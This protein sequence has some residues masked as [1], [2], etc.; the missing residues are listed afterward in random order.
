MLILKMVFAVLLAVSFASGQSPLPDLRIE[1]VGG[2]SVMYVTN[3]ASQPLTAFLIELAGYP[4]SSYS[5]AQDDLTDVIAPGVEK[6]IQ[7]SNMIIGAAP[8]YVKIRAAIFADGFTAGVAEKIA[9]TINRRRAVLETTRE[10]IRRIEKAV[11][12]GTEK[13]ALVVDLKEWSV[14]VRSVAGRSVIESAISRLNTHSAEET[15]ASLHASES[16]LAASKP[17]L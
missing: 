17:P 7:V 8:D 2:G 15:L 11:A 4:G 16:L 13:R 10:L 1:A 5:F 14:S 3:R 12:A 9:Q 6:R